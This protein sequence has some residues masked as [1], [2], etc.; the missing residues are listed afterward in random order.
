MRATTAAKMLSLERSLGGTASSADGGPGSA[1]AD[2]D[3][4]YAAAVSALRQTQGAGA[5]SDD[6]MRALSRAVARGNALTAS[7]REELARAVA[8]AGAAL[9]RAAA[10]EARAAAAE[11]HARASSSRAEPC[12][13]QPHAARLPPPKHLHP[14]PAPAAPRVFSS[15]GGIGAGSRCA[16]PATFMRGDG[17]SSTSS[18]GGAFIRSGADGR[19]GRHTVLVPLMPLAERRAAINAQAAPSPIVKRPRST[20]GLERFGFNSKSEH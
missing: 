14:V 1:A 20:H 13:S 2:A 5:A 19:G 7:V 15:L 18:D 12:I 3:A 6:V 10:A 8:S 17:T 16:A 9:A 11:S 4:V